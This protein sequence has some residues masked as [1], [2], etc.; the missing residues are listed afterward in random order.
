MKGKYTRYDMIGAINHWCSKNGGS[1]FTYIEKTKKAELEAIIAQYDINVDEMMLEQAKER[2]EAA[3]I[4]PKMQATIKKNIDFLL[5]KI[6][7]LESLLTAE[8][9]EK[10]VEYCN[11]QTSN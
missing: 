3:N 6:Q 1:Y 10:Y 4:I 11:S 2:E 7:M 9:Y 8:Q 5:D